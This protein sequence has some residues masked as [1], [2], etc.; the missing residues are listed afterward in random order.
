MDKM[1]FYWNGFEPIVRILIVGTLA[2]F[3]LIFILRISGKRTLAKM[4]AF[5]FVIT[6][7]IGSAFGR[8]LTAKNVSVSEAVTAFVLLVFLQ[9]VLS[10]IES[11]FTFFRK[12]IT[13]QPKILYYQSG[14]VEKNLRKERLVKKDILGSVRKKGFGSLEEVEVVILETDGTVSVIGKSDNKN[15]L[16]YNNLLEK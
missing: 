14:Y 11:H 9:F 8:V 6:V 13:S 1:D 2:Y 12:I 4:N 3:A 16:T 5:D 15:G 10:Y 7:T